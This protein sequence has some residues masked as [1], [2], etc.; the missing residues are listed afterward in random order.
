MFPKIS[1]LKT[2]TFVRKF[3]TSPF[4]AGL[5][6]KKFIFI[7][8]TFSLLATFSTEIQISFFVL[9]I[10]WF[11]IKPFKFITLFKGI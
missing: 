6:V 8:V 1:T 3:V 7:L 5:V 2:K 10:F 11:Q 9:T 4:F